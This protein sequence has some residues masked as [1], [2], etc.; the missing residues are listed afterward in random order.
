MNIANEPVALSVGVTCTAAELHV[1]P[2][3][4]MEILA[5]TP[6]QVLA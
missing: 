6:S 5:Q 2:A 1:Y 4:M 3:L